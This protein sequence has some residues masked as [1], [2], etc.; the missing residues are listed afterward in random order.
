M[1]KVSNGPQFRQGKVVLLF[2]ILIVL[3]LF[4]VG[5]IVMEEF[6]IGSLFLLID[7]ASLGWI[8][9][10]QGFEIDKRRKSVRKYKAFLFWK[11]GDWVSLKDYYAIHVDLNSYLIKQISFYRPLTTI[12]G[13]SIY[14]EKNLNYCVSFMSPV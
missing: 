2:F 13:S 11:T 6:A 9:D 10:I 12:G 14:Y 5:A 8:L 7:A 3:L 1:I 4:T